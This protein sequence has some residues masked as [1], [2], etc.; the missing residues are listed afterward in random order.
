MKAFA[1]FTALL[2][3]LLC[4][5]AGAFIV[6]YVTIVDQAIPQMPSWAQGPVEEWMLDI[7]Q[8]SEALDLN[9]DGAPDGR[10][11]D[12]KGSSDNS[13]SAGGGS[14]SALP[15]PTS[16]GNYTGPFGIPEGFPFIGPVQ[17]WGVTYENP[18]HG[19]G[20]KDPKYRNHTGFD[21]PVNT[22]TPLYSTIGGQVIWTAYTKGGWGRL[23]IIQNGDYQIWYAHMT[24]FDVQQGDIVGP[25]QLVGFSGGDKT[26]DDQAGNSSGPHLH[27]GIKRRTGPDTYVW[28]DPAEYFDATQLTPWGCSD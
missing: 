18:L 27:Y 28:V 24:S 1:L 10:N 25:G 2:T 22:N 14:I 7:P 26:S 8:D 23:L 3:G 19:C 21:F 6:G 16:W 9:N 17:K 13:V 15:G 12:T 20:F 11:D 4:F 5:G